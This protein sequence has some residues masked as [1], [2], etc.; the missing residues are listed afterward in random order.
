M[1]PETRKNLIVAAAVML[2]IAVA[3]V[4]P[5]ITR[6]AEMAGR[7]FRFFWWLFLLAGVALWLAIR[8][9]RK[10]K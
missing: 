9:G 7:E 6:F 1:K 8:S 10:K 3:I 5:R 4:F 2:A